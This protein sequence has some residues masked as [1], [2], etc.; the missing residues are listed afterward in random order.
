M[1]GA[2]GVL[3]RPGRLASIHRSPDVAV[4]WPPYDAPMPAPLVAF[5]RH[6]PL[7]DL[8]QEYL[9]EQGRSLLAGAS[10]AL[11]RRWGRRM[12]E[13]AYEW[14][15]LLDFNM[16]QDEIDRDLERRRNVVQLWEI[17]ELPPGF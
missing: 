5:L 16:E 11:W 4:D 13:A 6:C 1:G 8:I 12:R 14:A 15:M 2:V 3:Q 7:F 9:Y 17:G 10:V